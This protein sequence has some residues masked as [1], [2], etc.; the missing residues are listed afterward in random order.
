MSETGASPA[1]KINGTT[2]EK[3]VTSEPTSTGIKET[4]ENKNGI[5]AALA[6]ALTRSVA[7][8]FSRP[9]RLFR[10]AKGKHTIQITNN[11][12]NLIWLVDSQWMDLLTWYSKS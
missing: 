11:F 6:R 7:I 4:L 3:V 10:P 2:S 8:Y 1:T 12:I 5:A 9:V